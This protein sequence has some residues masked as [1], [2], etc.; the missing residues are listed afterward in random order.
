MGY[1]VVS[2]TSHHTVMAQR[3]CRASP[4]EGG[5][6]ASGLAEAMDVDMASPPATATQGGS[7][8]GL[9]WEPFSEVLLSP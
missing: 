1:H 5:L 8:S 3:R 2:Q 7:G 4:Q 9:P 6:E